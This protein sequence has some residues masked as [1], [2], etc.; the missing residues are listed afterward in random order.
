MNT[1][2]GE[3]QQAGVLDR[4]RGIVEVLAKAQAIT[5]EIVGCVPGNA[6][7]VEP[8]PDCALSYIDDVL[9]SVD[10][11]AHYLLEQLGGIQRRL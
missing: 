3:E 2:M 9:G 6:K 7:G 11:R 4:L 5:E 8:A 1:G 10:A